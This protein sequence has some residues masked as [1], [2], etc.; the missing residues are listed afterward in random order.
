[1]IFISFF[2]LFSIFKSH[3]HIKYTCFPLEHILENIIICSHFLLLLWMLNRTY[4]GSRYIGGVPIPQPIHIMEQYFIHHGEEGCGT[5]LG[6]KKTL[7]IPNRMIIYLEGYLMCNLKGVICCI[8]CKIFVHFI[9]KQ[10][11]K[12]NME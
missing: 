2:Y 6:K 5:A 4:L 11:W 10:G 9:V 7:Y 3:W 8:M 12:R 1:M